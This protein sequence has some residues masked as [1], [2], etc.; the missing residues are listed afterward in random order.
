MTQSNTKNENTNLRIKLL[1]SEFYNPEF[2]IENVR[3]FSPSQQEILKIYEEGVL[4]SE[5]II[6]D[7][8]LKISN[9]AQLSKSDITRYKLWLDQKYR[10]PYTGEMIPLNKLFTTS[11][12]IEHIIPQS[13]YFDDSL[14][15]KVICE[16]EVN[17]DK[18]NST[19]YEY[20]K[21]NSGKKIELAG[22]KEVTIFRLQE[23]EQFIQ[24]NFS[25]NRTK[26]KKLLMEDI[27]ESFIQRQLNDSRYISK[28]VKD[29]LSKIVREEKEQETT[30]KN[31][32]PING[33][34]T[35]KLKQEWGLNDI[36]NDII[37]P[38]FER[39]NKLTN[40]KNFGEWTN[41]GG[42]NVF[43]TQVPIELQKGFN[44]KRIDHRHHALDA[45]IIACATRSHISFLNN[46]YAL[47][48][49]KDL[50]YDLR[51]K[52]CAKKYNDE[53]KQNY[54]WT[55]NKP[56]E[57][58]TQDSKEILLK[59]IVSFKKNIRVINKTVNH[60]QKIED[61]K[62][63]MVKQTNGVNWAIRKPM[64]KDTVAGAVTLKLKKIVQLSTAIDQWEMISN[65]SLKSKIK[66][67]INEN[68][69]KK[70]IIKFFKDLDYKWNELNISKVEI[71]FIDSS[72]IASRTVLN[73]SFNSSKIEN[74]TDKGIQKILLKHLSKYNI[75]NDKKEILEQPELAFSQD[76]LDELNKNVIELNNGK[77]HFPITKV[78]I[79]EPR[80]NK[81]N[82]GSTGS[83]NT[84]FV[85]AAKGTNLFFAVY[86]DENGK[87]NYETIPLNVVIE[88]QK[89]GALE[90]I[91]PE[92]SSVP[93]K[94]SNGDNL[95]F[96]LSPNDLVIVSDVS[97]LDKLRINKITS[98]NKEQVAL[99]YKAISFTGTTCFF[100]RNDVATPIV[101]KV[102][103]S[104]LN[105][106]EKSIDGIM[107]KEFCLKLEID[108]LGKVKKIYQ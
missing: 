11:F 2:N 98:P 37:T 86:V 96:F 7:D 28:V 58:F 75:V 6:P 1:L 66:C 97:N 107:I 60:Y 45:L 49:K 93:Q 5:S 18:D 15:N 23:Y 10:S 108:R 53:N 70:K 65:K 67:L 83:K 54:K 95:L 42:N 104:A 44:K 105:K 30:S 14:S 84:K 71:Y 73:E 3:P 106:T 80:G 61:G 72:N 88:N 21:N 64:H 51:N 78:R 76:G 46:E 103:F 89:Q 100:I 29:L 36:W 47:A 16:S 50:R 25:K 102:E 62:K 34:I 63:I 19:A 81:F 82:V 41:K 79:F 59:T 55:F 94:N 26:M 8:I 9:A 40:S 35:S 57:T 31:V 43:Q 32:I 85:E 74:L 48:D 13:R 52:L 20:I 12:E 4:N 68:Y 38:R 77:F 99:I 92:F 24:D 69:D 56:W 27:P 39:L 91:K 90:N 101:N 17:K 33:S 87:R 22:K